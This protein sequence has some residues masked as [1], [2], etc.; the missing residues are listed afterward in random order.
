M[1]NLIYIL[2]AYIQTYICVCVSIIYITC[3]A[4]CCTMLTE[5]FIMVYASTKK[6]LIQK[7]LCYHLMIC[8]F[9]RQIHARYEGNGLHV[10]RSIDR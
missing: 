3:Q 9:H 6:I 2:H 10:S 8:I 7:V 1:V 5:N 4:S